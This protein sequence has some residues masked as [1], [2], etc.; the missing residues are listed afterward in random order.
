MDAAMPPVAL[1][2]R[3]PSLKIPRFQGFTFEVCRKK[4]LDVNS[5]SKFFTSI[6]L[7]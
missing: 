5:A 1:C 3:H 2:R 7:S 4:K 6:S